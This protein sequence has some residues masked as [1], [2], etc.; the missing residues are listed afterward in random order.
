[1]ACVPLSRTLCI[2]CFKGLYSGK[3]L[4]CDAW[5]VKDNDLISL[6]K[7]SLKK[8]PLCIFNIILHKNDLFRAM[9]EYFV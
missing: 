2:T 8:D 7:M 6:H 3:R 5:A 1:M 4:V 9:L